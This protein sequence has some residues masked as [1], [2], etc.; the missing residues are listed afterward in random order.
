VLFCGA[1]AA[2]GAATHLANNDLSGPEECAC[3]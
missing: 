3:G 2:G 1:A